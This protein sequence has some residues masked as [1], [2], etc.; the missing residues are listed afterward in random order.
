MDI[1]A[2]SAVLESEW[3]LLS[4][5][6]AQCM[7]KYDEEY[8]QDA[9]I[10]LAFVEEFCARNGHDFRFALQKYAN[11]VESQIREQ[12]AF[13]T[14]G[15]YRFSTETEANQALALEQSHSTY[16][17][18]LALS[19]I[20]SL[21]RYE[22]LR[23]VRRFVKDHVKPEDIC[24]QIGTGMGLEAHLFAMQ[25]ARLETY[26][27]NPVSP[28]CLEIWGNSAR[29]RFHPTA[30]EF[31]EESK[32]D[33][34]LL[35]EILE[36]LQDPHGM[37]RGA[38]RI[39][40]HGGRALLTF[41][42]RMPQVDHVYLFQS[43]SQARELIVESRFKIRDEAYFISSFL[44]HPEEE[45]A[46]LA[47]SSRLPCVYACVVEKTGSSGQTGKENSSDT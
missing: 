28:L 1:V 38:E 41:A 37:L 20:L 9:N 6:V 16:M 27:I 12:A 44:K 18:I 5:P 36:H 47:E 39:L 17:I 10:L 32:Y 26:D 4:L 11:Y 19:Y 33:H 8:R 21:H 35:V 31:R 23:Y 29:V 34:C 40:R 7:K 43:V 15:R 42:L 45:S 2:L 14:S 46:R 30:Y 25:G 13:S 22:L 3:R 24:L